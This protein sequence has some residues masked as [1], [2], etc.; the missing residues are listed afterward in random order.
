MTLEEFEECEWAFPAFGTP[1]KNGTICFVIDVHQINA[2]LLCREYP[3]MTTEEILTLIKGFL[4]SLS[5]D[6][7]MGYPSIPLNDEA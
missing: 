7:N 5:I 2:N 1:K 6:L 4:Y 3:L